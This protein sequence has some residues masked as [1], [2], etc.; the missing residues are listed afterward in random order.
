M[1]LSQLFRGRKSEIVKF[2]QDVMKA[3][4]LSVPIALGDR[5]MARH[6]LLGK[7]QSGIVYNICN[8]DIY[9]KFDCDKNDQYK[10][11]IENINRL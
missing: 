3:R 6:P 5:V 9:V 2:S 4:R 11:S 8:A 7:T 1:E 10:F